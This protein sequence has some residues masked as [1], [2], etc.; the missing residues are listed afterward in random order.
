V[1][2]GDEETPEV[3]RRG[4]GVVKMLARYA[5]AIPFGRHSAQ[6]AVVGLVS[7]AILAL[8]A[9]PATWAA[10]SVL[11]AHLD[12]PITN[13][14]LAFLERVLAKADPVRASAVIVEIDAASCGFD[15]SK[16]ISDLLLGEGTHTIAFV[17]REAGG[18]AALIALSCGHVVISPDGFLGG[19]EKGSE[20]A[21]ERLKR[22]AAFG[23]VAQERG[24]DRG[25]AEALVAARSDIEGLAERGKPLR[26]TA[27]E[28]AE[29]G[30]ADFVAGSYRD[31][32]SHYHLQ[33][34][35]IVEVRPSRWDAAL[36][37]LLNPWISL[38]LLVVGIR[39]LVLDLLTINTWGAAGTFGALAIAAAFIPHA[40]I[41]AGWVGFIVFF[42]AVWLMLLESY[43]LPGIGLAFVFGTIASFVGIYLGLGGSHPGGWLGIVAAVVGTYVMVAGF[44]IHLPR[45]HGWRLIS[46]R[47]R[48]ERMRMGAQAALEGRRGLTISRLNPYGSAVVDGVRVSCATDGG[49]IPEGTPVCVTRVEGDRVYVERAATA[50]RT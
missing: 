28:A 16:R 22:S 9:A 41:G 43:V 38:V 15:L 23:V 12:E 20:S 49:P 35:S 36:S 48:T 17:R 7:C 21:A 5:K 32:A 1:R 2:D 31:I 18:N 25:L 39:L 42:V 30:M 44:F 27:D 14:D 46:I 50:G 40:L 37:V 24:R 29:R 34:H 33:G 26:L 4:I 11:V 13:G 45:S 47:D 8:A 19:P 6:H 3:R 10:Q